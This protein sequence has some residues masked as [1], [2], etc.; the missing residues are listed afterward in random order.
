MESYWA[1]KVNKTS[2]CPENLHFE[3]KMRIEFEIDMPIVGV[4]NRGIVQMTIIV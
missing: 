4:I 2:Y 1:E 3:T